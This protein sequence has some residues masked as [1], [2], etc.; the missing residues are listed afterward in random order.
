MARGIS[1]EMMARREEAYLHYLQEGSVAKTCAAT[2]IALS[3][4]HQWKKEDTWDER[5][6]GTRG[7]L[8]EVMDKEILRSSEDIVNDIDD[9]METVHTKFGGAEVGNVLDAAKAIESLVKSRQLLTGQATSRAE[10][11][12]ESV[13][14][15]FDYS[16]L[17]ADTKEVHEDA[18]FSVETEDEDTDMLATSQRI[19]GTLA[20]E[21]VVL[22]EED[23]A[24]PAN[25]SG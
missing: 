14:A 18:V 3:T 16:T 7:A 8:Q 1:L 21:G 17:Y 13:T 23:A 2:G 15:T 10:T 11:S 9:M 19:A 22:T 12:T 24:R 25:A 4:L 6:D 5:R 20:T